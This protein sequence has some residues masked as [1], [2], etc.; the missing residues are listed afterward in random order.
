RHVQRLDGARPAVVLLAAVLLRVQQ[1][2]QRQRAQAD[3]GA[4]QKRTAGNVA[5][6]HLV[7]GHGVTP[8][9]LVHRGSTRRASP[10]PTP[11]GPARVPT[12]PPRRRRSAAPW[13]RPRP[14]CTAHGASPAE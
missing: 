11:P 6:K 3:A 1:R 2:G 4:G 10:T 14:S 5:T 9:S 8:P 13:P 7:G 12:P